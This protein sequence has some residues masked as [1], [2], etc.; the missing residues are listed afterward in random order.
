MILTQNTEKSK[1]EKM[2]SFNALLKPD[3]INNRNFN[4][5]M[6]ELNSLSNS[7]SI[8]GS[9]GSDF[10]FQENSLGLSLLGMNCSNSNRRLID[11]PLKLP[12][13]QNMCISSTKK[14]SIL[15]EIKLL[16]PFLK[17]EDIKEAL[18]NNSNDYE[19]TKDYLMK[20][21]IGSSIMNAGEKNLNGIDQKTTN[22][23]IW[24][25]IAKKSNKRTLAELDDEENSMTRIQDIEESKGLLN[26]TAINADTAEDINMISNN[27]NTSNTETSLNDQGMVLSKS[28]SSASL[29][30]E[31][32]IQTNLREAPFSRVD[33]N[34]KQKNKISNFDYDE[35][36]KNKDR[37]K[38]NIDCLEESERDF[39]VNNNNSNSSVLNVKYSSILSKSSNISTSNGSN[40]ISNKT[41]QSTVGSPIDQGIDNRNTQQLIAY[42]FPAAKRLT[43]TLGSTKDLEEEFH[44]SLFNVIKNS[45]TINKSFLHTLNRMDYLDQRITRAIT[46]L[47]Q[48]HQE[49]EF[50][51]KEN[52]KIED[53]IEKAEDDHLELRSEISILKER[54]KVANQMKFNYGSMN[55]DVK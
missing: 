23:K 8:L 53:Y 29:N 22:R 26:R 10:R 30:K 7:S 20:K 46:S 11:R 13:I 34:N 19:K 16:F 2:N 33:N 41:I 52:F 24:K 6:T 35:V 21:E 43:S 42:L 32:E 38:R 51:R 40:T 5:N 45:S 55:K 28:N 27:I 9:Q 12:K 25:D 47:Y 49:V 14:F 50:K 37:K 44:N 48:K 31:E 4:S 18:I 17:E 36:L 54:V 3:P 1:V 39:L 15:E